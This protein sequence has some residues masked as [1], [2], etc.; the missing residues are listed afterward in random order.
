MPRLTNISKTVLPLAARYIREHKSYLIDEYGW[1]NDFLDQVIEDLK[2]I[3][4]AKR[5]PRVNELADF[6]KS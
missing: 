4:E 2:D 1:S 6:A 3:H 5:K